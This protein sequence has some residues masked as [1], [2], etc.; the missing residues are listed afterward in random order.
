VRAD[1]LPLLRDPTGCGDGRGG[2]A[3]RHRDAGEALADSSCERPRGARGRSRALSAPD[4]S[5][6]TSF[7]IGGGP[8]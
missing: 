6:S 7:G 5:A 1:V 8:A 2:R 4:L 3:A